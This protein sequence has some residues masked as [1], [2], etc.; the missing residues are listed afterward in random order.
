MSQ[1]AP[2]PYADHRREPHPPDDIL[3]VDAA[4]R[5]P[6]LPP[7]ERAIWVGG[8]LAVPK[9]ESEGGAFPRR[10]FEAVR[11]DVRRLA[12]VPVVEVAVE[13]RGVA[14]RGVIDSGAGYYYWVLGPADGFV[15]R[16]A[17]PADEARANELFQ[18]L[19]AAEVALG[20]ASRRR[21][22]S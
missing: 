15:M 17:E 16:P 6:R 18:R 2:Y 14:W 19:L 3:Y 8:A 21:R 11:R 20:V 10:P 7:P 22:V 9:K 13:R 4:A 1:S 5:Q 12:G